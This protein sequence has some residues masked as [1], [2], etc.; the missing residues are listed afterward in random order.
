[1]KP[2]QEGWQVPFDGPVRSELN[3]LVNPKVEPTGVTKVPPPQPKASVQSSVRPAPQ[4]KWESTK[5]EPEVVEV[6]DEME[7]AKARA[8][9]LDARYKRRVAQATARVSNV[10]EHLKKALAALGELLPTDGQAVM[11]ARKQLLVHQQ[12]LTEVQKFVSAENLAA[13]TAP[14][15]VRQGLESLIRKLRALQAEV[16]QALL[17]LPSPVK[18]E[19]VP[20]PAYTPMEHEHLQQL[21]EM[22]PSVL[23]KIDQAEDEAAQVKRLVG[24]ERIHRNKDALRELSC[25]QEQRWPPLGSL[26]KCTEEIL[27]DLHAGQ[28]GRAP[29]RRQAA[30]E[31]QRRWERLKLEAQR[32]G[33][34][35]ETI[36][37]AER[38]PRQCLG[39]CGSPPS[40]SLVEDEESFTCASST[41]AP[42]TSAR[43]DETLSLATAELVSEIRL[44]DDWP[45]GARQR[46]HSTELQKLA[47]EL[48]E[49][50][51]QEY[52]ALMASIE[53]IQALMEAEVAGD[54]RL[55]SVEE[56]E[57][58]VARRPVKKGTEP[59]DRALATWPSSAP[60]ID[61]APEHR[62]PSAGAGCA[63]AEV[64]EPKGGSDR[65]SACEIDLWLDAALEI[66]EIYPLQT[67]PAPSVAVLVPEACR[68]ER[69]RW[70]DLNSDSDD[71]A[72]PAACAA[73]LTLSAPA[74]AECAR[75]QRLLTKSS[76]S[77]RSWRQVRGKGALGQRPVDRAWNSAGFFR[78][79]CPKPLFAQAEETLRSHPR[80]RMEAPPPPPPDDPPGPAIEVTSLEMNPAEECAFEDGLGLAIGFTSDSPLLGFTW[81]ISY[82]VDTAKR[83]YIVQVGQ[84]EPA[85][86][87]PGP[88]AMT[89]LAE[90][91]SIEEVPK[92]LWQ[93]SNGLLQLALTS[94]AGEELMTVNLVVQIRVDES[95]CL[96]R[97]IFNPME[98]FISGKL[99]H[100]GRFAPLVKKQAID[101]FSSL[102]ERLNAAQKR[103]NPF[104][105]VRQ[106]YERRA[107]ARKLYEELSSKLAG[108]EIEVEKA[109]MMT[110]PMG[111]DS[112][113]GMKERRDRHGQRE[114]E[115]TEATLTL[116]QTML[117]QTNRQ[118]E[119]KLKQ[120]EDVD[121]G[122]QLKGLLERCKL[123]QEKLD[124]L[125]SILRETQ[126]IDPAAVAAHVHGVL[127]ETQSYVARKSVEV[128]KFSDGP[129]EAVKEEARGEG[130]L[131]K[132]M[133]NYVFTEGRI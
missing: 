71:A 129:G 126:A 81:R 119:A 50:L 87:A 114:G 94:P 21:E 68:R 83:R 86:Y 17:G 101:E 30:E 112:D 133:I 44:L 38:R 37:E 118:V 10:E 42:S 97:Y 5:V 33:V 45:P 85:D 35:A 106:D 110:A 14:M 40:K 27:G 15:M 75:C 122:E 79:T 124:D 105:S 95:G 98:R 23:E 48:K 109:A 88:N 100:V 73:S 22:M 24:A 65:S 59:I 41:R 120:L 34:K 80:G 19:T 108:A 93:Q 131:W 72:A 25:F 57:G 60:P 8:A 9:A 58:F 77:R 127:A 78:P 16:K 76:F 11:Q 54:A 132:F 117:A 67:P 74:V 66:G 89:Y 121:F 84:T 62:A 53:E 102:Q 92:A 36:C 91:L 96:R 69:P 55:P 31:A 2:P 113:E 116:A 47:V 51:D 39:S 49:Q 115:E 4:A 1:M 29:Q 20:T 82:V 28:F 70:A 99:S 52:T 56:L 130:D 125:R 26:Q 103:L 7:D 6:D 107:Q 46:R 43:V 111:T 18:A 13:K 61:P 32:H 3:V 63:G 12:K 123:A 128:S 64:V 104:K 90:G